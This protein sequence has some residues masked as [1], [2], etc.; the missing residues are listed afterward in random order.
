[1]KTFLL[2]L[3]GALILTLGGCAGR[4]VHRLTDQKFAPTPADQEVKLYVNRIERPHLEIALVQSF[5]SGERDPQ[6]RREQLSQLRDRAR[7][8]G[9][10]AVVD[11]RQLKVRSRGMVPD[12]RAPVPMIRHGE[13]T[14]YMLRGTAV[15]FD[16]S[17]DATMSGEPVDDTI[18]TDGADMEDIPEIDT[19]D[20]DDDLDYETAPAGLR[21]TF[22]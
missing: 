12:E 11:I 20:P 1:M 18:V 8:L 9:A 6:T 3:I 2:A 7:K 4:N 10:D 5:T 19:I 15:R 14:R 16:D 13:Y 22:D 21:Q 17:D